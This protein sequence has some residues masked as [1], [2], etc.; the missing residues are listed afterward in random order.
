MIVFYLCK[1][2]FRCTECPAG[3]T[4]IP[5]VNGCYK[6]VNRGL[7]WADAG[8]ACQSLHENAHLLVIN[9]AVEQLAVAGMLDST[10][11]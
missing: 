5:S 11:S 4:F 6:V 1:E 2:I 8:L 9:D 10:D 3:F 7:K